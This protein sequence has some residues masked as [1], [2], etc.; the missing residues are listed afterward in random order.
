MFVY[1]YQRIL[2]TDGPIWLILI[3]KPLIGS[4]KVNNFL[5]IFWEGTSTSNRTKKKY[6]T[7]I[8]A[9]FK[10]GGSN[11]HYNLPQVSLKESKGVAASI[12][13]SKKATIILKIEATLVKLNK[14]KNFPLQ[15]QNVNHN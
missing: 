14:Y 6:L 12:L 4:G 10:S 1:V 2:L 3:V 8:K 11:Y 9:K 5:T 7:Q 13:C 15:K